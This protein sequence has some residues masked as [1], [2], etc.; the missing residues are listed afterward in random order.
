MAEGRFREDLYYRLNEFTVQV[1]PLRER[2]AVVVVLAS[3]FLSRFTAE[4]GRLARGFSGS[5]SPRSGIIRG[6]KRARG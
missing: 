2:A 1:P 5:R 4:H 3:F 6:R